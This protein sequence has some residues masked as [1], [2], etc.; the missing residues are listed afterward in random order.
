MLN[1]LPY[2]NV[3]DMPR[4][5]GGL[6]APR[7]SMSGIIGTTKYDSYSRSLGGLIQTTTPGNKPKVSTSAA[8]VPRNTEFSIIGPASK[9]HINGQHYGQI[10]YPG[11]Y[12]GPLGQRV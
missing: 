10:P 4:Q 1:K 8:A 11:A 9:T 6:G 3:V 12:M 2:M 7:Y 5:M